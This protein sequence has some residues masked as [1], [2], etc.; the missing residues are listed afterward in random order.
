[1]ATLVPPGPPRRMLGIDLIRRMQQDLLGF[2]CEMKRSYGDTV[3]Y[4]AGPIRMFQFTHP[5][6]IQEVLVKHARK[7]HKPQR[8]KQVF[9]QWDGQGLLLS[10]GDFWARQRRLIQSAFHPHRVRQY[11]T[12]IVEHTVRMLDRWNAAKEVN[13]VD[14]MPRLTLDI[15]GQTL[16]GADLGDDAPAIATAVDVLQEVSMIESSQ[17][18]PRPDWLPTDFNRRKRASIEALH[19]LVNRLIRE[20]RASGADH[21][22]LLSMLLLAKDESGDGRGMSDV[23]VRDEATTLLLAG[24]ETTAVS[25]MWT[26]Y[27]LAEHAD[28]QSKLAEAIRVQLGNRLPTVEDLPNLPLVEMAFKEAI[29]MRGP[30]YFFGR[31]AVE[32][33]EI[34]GVKIAAGNHVNLVPYITHHDPRWFEEPEAFRPERFTPEREAEL[35]RFAYFPFGGGPRVCIG[36][37]MATLE[38]TLILTAIFQ[39]FH[40]RLAP[41]Q[42]DPGM[43]A[44]VSLHPRGALRLALEE[45]R[46]DS[47]SG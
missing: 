16:F 33:V 37:G 22:D 11:G 31:E 45:R 20:R 46:A 26:L 39:R 12:A 10:E 35:P 2:C 19:G 24:H 8:V 21:G 6:Q 17:I 25:L 30:V 47:V 34:G 44:Q 13:V 27:Y 14:E 23:Q 15:V 1:M 3:A 9:G 36:K 28:V 4:H 41:G 40:V 29:R 38:A 43:E 18:V 7:F 42:G 32:P 5:D